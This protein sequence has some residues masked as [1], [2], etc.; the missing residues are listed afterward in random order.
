MSA[1]KVDGF[2]Q[3]ERKYYKPFRLMESVVYMV[4]ILV[5]Y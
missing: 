5:Y 4:L 1:R 3:R 2:Y